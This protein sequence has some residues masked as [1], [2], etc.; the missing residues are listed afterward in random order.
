MIQTDTAINPGNSGGPLLNS[1]GQLIGVNTA[2]ASMTG[3]YQ[4]IGFAIPSA[5]ALLIKDSLLRHG[6]V[7][8]GWMGVS[9]Q[10]VTPD[11]AEGMGLTP[12][13]GVLI[14]DVG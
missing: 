9:I 14:A 8:R 3:G 2:I 10:N 6:K 5:M 11:L 1:R 13:K 12:G 4:G 7:V